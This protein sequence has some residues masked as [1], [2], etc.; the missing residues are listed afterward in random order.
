[1]MRDLEA[2]RRSEY[3]GLTGAVVRMAA[4]IGLDVAVFKKAGA[5]IRERSL[6]L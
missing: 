2:G 4:E 3:G 6:L 5:M 1:M